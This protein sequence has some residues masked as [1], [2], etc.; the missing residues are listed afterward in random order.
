MLALSALCTPEQVA[1]L[2]YRE[3]AVLPHQVPVLWERVVAALSEP[4]PNLAALSHGM[5]RLIVRLMA[6]GP[7][8]RCIRPM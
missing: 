5:R 8:A 6:R 4:I 2:G 3:Y 7:D 1:Q